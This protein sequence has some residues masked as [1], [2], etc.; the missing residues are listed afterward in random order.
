MGSMEI[1][2]RTLLGFA[3][4]VLKCVVILVAIHSTAPV[5]A[6]A[7][8]SSKL[9]RDAW[10]NSRSSRSSP[11]T[12]KICDNKTTQYEWG[13]ILEDSIGLA[14]NTA[15]TALLTG[16]ILLGAGL[17][18]G[19]SETL[20]DPFVS[21]AGLAP[22]QTPIS[23]AFAYGSL[24]ESSVSSS[25]SFIL[26]P[27]ASIVTAESSSNE[28]Q[29]LRT[30]MPQADDY[31]TLD[32]VW[33]LIDKYYID[34]TFGGQ[35]DWNKVREKYRYLASKAKAD[36]AKFDVVTAMVSSLK[37]KYSRTLDRAQYSAIQKYDLIG[38]GVTLMP[39]P[40]KNIIVGAPPIPGSEAARVGMSEG[41]FVDAINGIATAGRNA[42]DI[43]DQISLDP[44]AKS[45][46]MTVRPKGTDPSS[47]AGKVLTMARAFEEVKNPVTFKVSEIRRDGTKVGYVK[48]LEFNALVKGSL[49]YALSQ[50]ESAG[51]NAYVID[52]RQNRG[53]AF[54]SAVEI[55]SLF[56]E[57]RIAT[58]VVDNT[59][60]KLPFRTAKGQLAIDTTD[61]VVI[62]IDGNS[63]SATEVFAGS[64]HDNCR[65]VLM[66][67]Q[68]FGKGLI[69][70]VYGLK[71]GAGLVLTVARYVTP[72]GND[73]QG[74]GI[75]PD[76]GPKD[77]P[78]GF[79][80]LGTDTSK[81]DF[82]N[83]R[84]RLSMCQMP[85]KIS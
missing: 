5:W 68:S 78:M 60:E 3:F 28:K 16:A 38:V 40:N 52:I 55:S 21:S 47:A 59:K 37:D 58:Y 25:H 43:I 50:L 29:L 49:E 62:W 10:S 17:P 48:I 67:E 71:N 11:S 82:N 8:K 15:L 53:G 35:N 12:S 22:L 45:L 74:V 31:S 80:G 57:D 32:E 34:R 54:Q 39:D 2:L 19:A 1:L 20:G 66:G 41:D 81:I 84:D 13:V 6:W 76:L 77:L 75:T 64:L 42:F 56:S 14:H 63:A 4:A 83:I 69:Q 46:T 70:A 65:A 33:T 85:D 44:S 26:N 79:L 72:S 51:V 23:P 73:I 27:Q 7:P 30:V 9:G 18:V 61:P 36:D 24:A